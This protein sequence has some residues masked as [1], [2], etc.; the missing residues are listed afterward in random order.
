MKVGIYNRHWPTLGGGER[1]GG[2]IAEALA[3]DNDVELLAHER[4]DLD[5]VGERLRLNLNGVGLQVI[6]TDPFAV[7]RAS[8]RYD[9]FIN[10]AYMSH[11]RSDANR[12]I[13]VV[14]FPTPPMPLPWHKRAAMRGL[15]PLVSRNPHAPSGWG[16]GFYGW[17]A[18]SDAPKARLD[19]RRRGDVRPRPL[20]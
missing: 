4:L 9:L 19:R 17:G 18:W 2:G 6:S 13:Y 10:V 7:A 5:D 20:R 1:Y 11:D 15:G 16:R 3:A 8:A 14:H 12:S